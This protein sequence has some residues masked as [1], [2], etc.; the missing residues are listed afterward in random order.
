LAISDHLCHGLLQ[1]IGVTGALSLAS[2]LTRNGG[3]KQYSSVAAVVE[4]VE[5]TMDYLVT[6]WG[7]VTNAQ[8]WRL[9]RGTPLELGPRG[10]LRD[11]R[12]QLEV[13][14]PAPG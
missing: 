14:T 10:L 1:A 11:V 9:R 13:V 3:G 7:P 5:K 4:D 6:R 2:H 12:R 8:G